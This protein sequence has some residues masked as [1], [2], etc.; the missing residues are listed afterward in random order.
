MLGL[1]S[2]VSRHYT[3]AERNKQIFVQR[4][5]LAVLHSKEGRFVCLYC[6]RIET[7]RIP[8]AEGRG[9]PDGDGVK[10]D[11]YRFNI[12]TNLE[13]WRL[14]SCLQFTPQTDKK[15]WLG[16]RVV[17]VLDSGAAGPGFKS[18]PLRCRITLIGKLFT[19]IVRP[20]FTKQR[21]R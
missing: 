14:Q 19:P 5:T 6:S 11:E 15:G 7:I 20:L 12:S 3:R 17:S 10:N 8:R 16:S 2:K 4:A 18:Q 13:T 9:P 21:N 1:V